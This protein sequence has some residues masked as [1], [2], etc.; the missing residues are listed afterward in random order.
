MKTKLFRFLAVI[1]CVAIIAG[2]VF[3]F[4]ER[5][6]REKAGEPEFPA[7]LGKHIEELS[8]TIPGVPESREEGPASAAEAEFMARAYPADTISVANMAAAR[9]AFSNAQGRPFPSG[10]GRPGTWVSVG[11]SEALYPFTDFRNSFLYV[12]NA[13]IAGGRTT[14]IAIAETCQPGNC[15]MYIT[16]AGG[17]VWRTRNALNGQPSWQYLAGPFGINAAGSVYLDPNDPSGNTV[18]VGTGEANICGSGCVAG[19]G[20]YKST[21]GGDTWTKLGGNTFDG[22][23]IGVIV[24]KP[25]SPNTIYLG[26]TTALRGM[27][28]VCCSG[29]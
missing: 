21:N 15:R 5:A 26:V 8:K 28:S 7:A 25:G 18:Y 13:Y 1:V 20:L 29:V 14:S 4:R 3:Y 9:S 10:R 19:T 16:P 22:L 24:V 2:S 23:G 6:E 11:P 12:P 27:S 17:G